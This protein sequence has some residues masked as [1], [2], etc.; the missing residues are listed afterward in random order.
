M[1]T[2]QLDVNKVITDLRSHSVHMTWLN[3]LVMVVALSV[4]GGIYLHSVQTYERLIA[5]ADADNAQYHKDLTDF[6]TQWKADQQTIAQLQ[7]QKAQIQTQIVY[8]DKDTETKIV[9]VAAPNRSETQVSDDVQSAYKFPPL[10]VEGGVFSFT[11]PETQQFVV[12]RLDRD[13]LALDLQ[14]TQ[15]Q[16][17]LESTSNVTLANDV[18]V[19]GKRLEESKKVITDYQ[20]IAKKSKF[21][22]FLS[23]AEKVGLF[24]G[25]IYLGKRL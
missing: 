9:A 19:A 8:R 12:T 20:K 13:R 1:E 16:L 3:V 4:V 7:Q 14:D 2:P 17:A 25:G 22:T 18:V 23:N 21:K 11:A 5:R 10:K 6:Q 15:K 24:V